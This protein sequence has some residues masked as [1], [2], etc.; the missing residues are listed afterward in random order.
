MTRWIICAVLISR[1]GI[2]KKPGW[3]FTSFLGKEDG[4]HA[5]RPDTE[6]EAIDAAVGK[7]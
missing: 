4:S 6:E 3:V 1:R 7:T 2:T 5:L